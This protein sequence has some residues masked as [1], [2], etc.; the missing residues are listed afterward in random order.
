MKHHK[1]VLTS[2]LN[3]YG[4]LFGGQMLYWIDSVGYITA[5]YD[6]PGNEFVTRGLA[7]VSF[8][9]TIP[10]GSILEFDANILNK[11]RASVTYKIDVYC[12][13]RSLDNK[14]LVFSTDITF[15]SI[16]ANGNGIRIK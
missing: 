10:A 14:H 16:D 15:V 4:F 8:K 11:G 2:H 9:K 3:H 7:D 12:D 13:D 1:L 5:N 6:F